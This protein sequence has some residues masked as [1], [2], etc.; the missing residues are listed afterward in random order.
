MCAMMDHFKAIERKFGK[1][2]NIMGAQHKQGQFPSNTEL[3]PKEQCK[4]I[5]LRSDTTYDG[6]KM[7]EKSEVELEKIKNKEIEVEQEQGVVS[8]KRK[9]GDYETVSLTEECSALIQAKLPA[10][11]KD[12]VR[13]HSLI[14]LV[15]GRVVE[16]YVI[17]ERA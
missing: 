1:I 17:L 13:S 9:M 10:K 12:P 3:N 4:V 15:K 6:L 16:I 7:S 11:F 5:Q 8:H 14:K 2:V